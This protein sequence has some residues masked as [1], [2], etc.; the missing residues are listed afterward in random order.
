MGPSLPRSAKPDFPSPKAQCK[1]PPPASALRG[2]LL[3]RVAKGAHDDAHVEGHLTLHEVDEFLGLALRQQ[4]AVARLNRL[5]RHATQR[6]HL[7]RLREAPELHGARPVAPHVVR[8][9]DRAGGGLDDEVHRVAVFRELPLPESAEGP[10]VYDVDRLRRLLGRGDDVGVLA[11]L[12]QD[13][14]LARAPPGLAHR[15]DGDEEVEGEPLAESGRG[16][17]HLEQTGPV[18]LEVAAEA[19]RRAEEGGRILA[20]RDRQDALEGVKLLAP[21]PA[22]RHPELDDALRRGDEDALADVEVA[23]EVPALEAG[24]LR[25]V[26]AQDGLLGEPGVDQGVRAPDA[27]LELLAGAEPDE[28]DRLGLLQLARGLRLGPL[29]G[30]AG[31]RQVALAVQLRALLV[32]VLGHLRPAVDAARRGLRGGDPDRQALAVHDLQVPQAIARAHRGHGVRADLRLVPERDLHHRLRAEGRVL[33]RGH[34]EVVADVVPE[35]AVG[36][37][38]GL[39]EPGEHRLLRVAAA[40]PGLLLRAA[41]PGLPA[42]EGRSAPVGAL[43][44]DLAVGRAADQQ[45]LDLGGL[46]VR[47]HEGGE[48]LVLALLHQAAEVVLA[49]EGQARQELVQAWPDDVLAGQAAELDLDADV[50]REAGELLEG[51]DHGELDAGDV[52]QVHE[53]GLRVV[54][55]AVDELLEGAG[56]L[57]DGA[58]EEV[59]LQVEHHDLVAVERQVVDLL[60]GPVLR[61]ASHVRALHRAHDVDVHGEAHE[62]DGH[63]HEANAASDVEVGEDGRDDC[64]E[65][66]ADARAVQAPAV[67]PEKGPGET[68]AH[69]EEAA[70]EEE[71]RDDG[72]DGGGREE[73][74][75]PEQGGGPGGGPP[76]AAVLLHRQGEGGHVV[77]RVPAEQPDHEVRAAER[78]ELLVQ[79]QAVLLRRVRLD[80]GHVDER[81]DDAEKGRDEH[82]HDRLGGEEGGDVPPGDVVHRH[83]ELLGRPRPRRG[84]AEPGGVHGAELAVQAHVQT[85]REHRAVEGHEREQEEDGQDRQTGLL[86]QLPADPGDAL[87]QDQG[88]GDA[89]DQLAGRAD[90]VQLRGLVPVRRDEEPLQLQVQEDPE[91]V[92]H[93]EDADAAQEAAEHGERQ[94]QGVDGGLR[95]G[96][97]D[98]HEAHEEGHQRDGEQGRGHLLPRVAHV[99]HD[100]AHHVG[101]EQRGWRGRTAHREGEEARERQD[102]D[103]D[104][105]GEDLLRDGDVQGVAKLRV[106]RLAE[107]HDGEGAEGHHHDDSVHETRQQRGDEGLVRLEAS[108]ANLGGGHAPALEELPLVQRHRIEL[109][110][111]AVPISLNEIHSRKRPGSRNL[112]DGARRPNSREKLGERSSVPN[113]T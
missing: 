65:R 61:G 20:D 23:R 60:L 43:V 38:G 27:L 93:E 2:H 88:D 86:A 3:L 99:A 107:D 74:A 55:R 58:P 104:A 21:A 39:H 40:Q 89:Q 103:E 53:D 26:V 30:Q 34:D 7:P 32:R 72:A 80:A 92:P 84:L 112:L 18:H 70:A 42:P 81:G 105:G 78:H 94:L 8:A 22:P 64:E 5:D 83:K 77:P 45:L 41:Q 95:G 54:V 111:D 57:V 101:H 90:R 75:E 79:V 68:E 56:D 66:D 85:A 10:L 36:A 37:A 71:A 9:Q 25:D 100:G 91:R 16:G 24:E 108:S 28:V 6:H 67:V 15:R 31:P 76:G 35:E 51:V 46:V 62:V 4:R 87:E 48:E 97:G 109:L 19:L 44:R 29:R 17:R 14:V 11:G 110:R 59:A 49:R 98:E 113:G 63:E 12:L 50:A 106:L 73:D 69:L 47:G 13:R 1:Y 82:A 96:D 33:H 102:A 52:A